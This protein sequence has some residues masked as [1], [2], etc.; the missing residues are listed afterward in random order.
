MRRLLLWLGLLGLLVL[1]RPALAAPLPSEAA[2]LQALVSRAFDYPEAGLAELRQRMPADFGGDLARE[3]LWLT[4][5]GRIL[6]AVGEWDELDAIATRLS[7][8]PGGGDYAW[9]LRAQLADRQNKPSSSLSARALAGFEKLCRRGD[10]VR[11]LATGC[12][13]GAA[14]H[15]IRLL[16]RAQMD[17]GSAAPS[18][19]NVR[20]GIALAR[21]AGDRRELVQQLNTLAQ[22]HQALGQGAAASED[23]QNA[24]AEAQAEPLLM[25]QVL[26]VRGV[27]LHRNGDAVGA[28]HR[29]EQSLAYAQQAG[30]DTLI[31]QLRV[32]LVDA[33]LRQD[34]PQ[35]ALRQAQLAMPLIERQ[36]NRRFERVLRH[37][38]VLTYIKLRQFDVAQREEAKLAVPSNDPAEVVPRAR[39]LRELAT[40][41][42]EAGQFKESLAAYHAEREL[43]L[44]ASERNREAALEE[45]RRKYDSS[46]KERDIELLARD[47]ALKDQQLANRKLA[48]KVGIALGVLLVLSLVLGAIILVRSR[49]AHESLKANQNLL[50]TQSERDPLTG[51]SNRRHLLAVM[52]QLAR[53]DR[54]GDFRGALLMIDIDHFKNVNDQHGHGAGDTVIVEVSQRILQAVRSTDL[55]VRWGGEEFLVF[56]PELAAEPLGQLA[57]RILRIIGGTPVGTDA[58]PLDVTASIGFASFPLGEHLHLH[59]EQA[60]NWT[61]MAL[62]KA[63]AEGRNRAVGILAV[64]GAAVLGDA[65]QDFDAAC[66]R[67]DVKHVGIAGPQR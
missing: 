42:A 29:T 62:Y 8:L 41:W 21:A 39:E 60:V 50:R 63:K 54:G 3:R 44:R 26:N 23:L 13:A 56:A 15:A 33:Y 59:W 11:S 49:R 46:A 61:D 40:A 25:A 6:I 64:Q 51:L 55:V 19:A 48:Q 9:L 22:V 47:S 12:D 10:E 24:E 16:A 20:F 28:M 38:L 34:R 65:P 37:N 57:E 4:A 7:A 5:K 1:A 14:G 58:G 32:N 67:G 43:T 45:L 18:E 35:D 31:A 36:K 27:I 53:A 2:E 30:A 66:Q 17:E 52:D